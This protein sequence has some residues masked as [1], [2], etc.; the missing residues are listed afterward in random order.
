MIPC[1]VN[2]TPVDILYYW[3]D[4]TI[5]KAAELYSIC[6]QMPKKLDEM[7]RLI[8]QEEPNLDQ[9]QEELTKRDY[10]EFT[11][12]YRDVFLCLSNADKD[13]LKGVNPKSLEDIYYNFLHGMVFTLLNNGAGYD[14]KDIE[15]FDF[16]AYRYYL[17]ESTEA[18]GNI[19]PLEQIKTI[20]FTESNDL[21][22]MVVDN[23]NG[24]DYVST[25]IAVLC[26]RE[27]EKYNKSIITERADI[28]NYLTM[29]IV[30]DVFFCFIVSST[31]YL[32]YT[33]TC[34]KVPW[35]H[36]NSRLLKSQVSRIWDGMAE[37]LIWLKLRGECRKLI[38]TRILRR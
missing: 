38:I 13:M 4:I 23:N 26:L 7:Y 5:I 36:R 17:P 16:D 2:G 14:A 24:Y 21:L 30:Y 19:F 8:K 3:G 29:D 20:Q 34:S 28:F 15:Y 25:I 11:R 9:W 22:K 10:R 37:L 32:D 6:K 31:G 18:F 35:V 1:N 27:G 33:R 12:Y